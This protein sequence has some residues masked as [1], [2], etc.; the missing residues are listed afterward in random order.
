MK[1]KKI[2]IFSVLIVIILICIGMYSKGLFNIEKRVQSPDG[3]VTTTVY[4]CDV[5]EY[6]FKTSAITIRDKGNNRGD[7]IYHNAKF[8]GLWWS[9]DSKYRLISLSY[10][11]DGIY[12]VVDNFI[13]NVESNL[14]AYIDGV[15]Y[16]EK[17]LVDIIMYD[18]NKKFIIEYDFKGWTE[19]SGEMIFEFSFKGK[20]NLQHRG[21]FKYNYAT[22]TK[23]D[24][25]IDS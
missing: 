2:V 11:N 15:L 20:D 9:P 4:N 10:D 22:N 25:K 13:N 8:N 23:S 18:D 5:T 16:D 1:K 12:Y 3:K 6:P 7:K 17:A 19:V 24:F 21:S 14:S